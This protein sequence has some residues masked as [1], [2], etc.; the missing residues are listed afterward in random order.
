MNFEINRKNMVEV[1]NNAVKVVNTKSPLAVLQAIKITAKNNQ[2]TVHATDLATSIAQTIEGVVQEP[3]EIVLPY[4]AID[5]MR[6]LDNDTIR[7]EANSA[8]QHAYVIA[9][10]TRTFFSCFAS[11]DFPTFPEPQSIAAE[12][13][14]T[15]AELKEALGKVSYAVGTDAAREIFTGICFDME[16]GKL[17]LAAT[18]SFRLSITETNANPNTEARPLVPSFIVKLL[19]AISGCEEVFMTF[20]DS[21]LHIKAGATEIVSVLVK[22]RYPSYKQLL[23]SDHQLVLKANTKELK[24]AMERASLF[25]TAGSNNAVQFDL[26]DGVLEITAGEGSAKYTEESAVETLL[27]QAIGSVFLNGHFTH[28]AISTI[29]TE[30]TELK[31]TTQYKPVVITPH[32]DNKSVALVVP[33]RISQAEAAA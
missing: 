32:G 30:A 8:T 26:K 25:M 5:L 1:L 3:G 16:P 15:G 28:D 6:K 27:G 31:F 2:V 21:L 19:P 18:D 33:I 14:I 4:K 22:G 29:S 7:I 17:I 9:G 24:G 13:K 11:E 10:K 12:F 20:S 23:P